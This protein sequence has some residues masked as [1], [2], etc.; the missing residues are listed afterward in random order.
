MRKLIGVALLLASLVPLSEADAGG[1][2]T[3]SF[4]YYSP[5]VYHRQVV[6][7]VNVVPVAVFQPVAIPTFSV[8]YAPGYG[9]P[10]GPG[11]DVQALTVLVRRLEQRIAALSVPQQQAPGRPAIEAPPQ[12]AAPQGAK[13][14]GW[15]NVLKTRCASCH[16]GGTAKGKFPLF[17]QPGQLAALTPAQIGASIMRM[18]QAGTKEQMPPAPAPPLTDEEFSTVNLA[19]ARLLTQQ[20]AKAPPAPEPA[21]PPM[22]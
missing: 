15:V 16:T 18:Q 12:Q 11:Q 2:V 5:P 4:T 13:E 10:P 21:P 19:M 20:A 8:G 3:R 17:T 22:P 6:A 7:A 14:T 9:G 1:C